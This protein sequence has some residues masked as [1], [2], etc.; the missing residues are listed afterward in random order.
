MPPL[1]TAMPP[2][3]TTQLLLPTTLPPPHTT[4]AQHP[5]I[6]PPYPH[7]N[8][9]PNHTTLPLL[10]TFPPQLFTNLSTT[11]HLSSTSQ[12]TT[13]HPPHTRSQS[14]PPS[15]TPMS[16]PW[17]MITQ[18]QLSTL[19]KPL[20]ARQL[21]DPTPLLYLMAVLSMSSTLPTITTDILL[22]SHTKELLYTQRRSHTT[23][24]PLPTSPPLLHT[25]PPPLLTIPPPLL[26]TRNQPTT[27]PPPHTTVE[28]AR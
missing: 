8:P 5:S 13:Q 19:E 28:G 21:A 4:Q 1:P 18:R 2:L 17:L 25:S 6:T 22:R 24:H 10:L 7:T 12:P 20:M 15:H 14:I 3:P 23:L 9:P 11:L 27:P 26:T 16:M